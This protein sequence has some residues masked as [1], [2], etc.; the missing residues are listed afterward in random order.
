MNIGFPHVDE[1]VFRM[2]AF[3]FTVHTHSIRIR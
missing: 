3:D 1:V 2:L